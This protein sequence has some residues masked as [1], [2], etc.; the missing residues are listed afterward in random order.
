MPRSPHDDP[1]PKVP[2][3][4]IV[5]QL[6]IRDLQGKPFVGK[7]GQL[8]DKILDAGGFDSE[9]DVFITNSVFRMPPGGGNSSMT[10]PGRFLHERFL[11][12]AGAAPANHP[13]A[14]PA[15]AGTC[16]RGDM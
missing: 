11:R 3:N 16:R 8:L 2:S 5:W 12:G 13:P 7:A 6:P 15:G 4:W 14:A 10:P 9:K 1:D